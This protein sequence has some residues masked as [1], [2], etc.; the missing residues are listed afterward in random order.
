[1]FA[2]RVRCAAQLFLNGGG[3]RRKL[4]RLELLELLKYRVLRRLKYAIHAA[5]Y[6]HG[7][8]D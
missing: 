7:E 3:W 2:A 8:H 4:L 6:Y 5:Q 1:M